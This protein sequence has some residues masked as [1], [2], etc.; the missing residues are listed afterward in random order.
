[1]IRARRPVTVDDVRQHGAESPV[2]RVEPPVRPRRQPREP[3]QVRDD[4]L[5][6]KLRQQDAQQSFDLA[7]R[8]VAYVARQE[9][10]G[11]YREGDRPH[12]AV[13]G[14]R[15]A[16]RPRVDARH[17]DIPHRAHIAGDLRAMECWLH[18]PPLPAVVFAARQHQPVAYQAPG[19]AEIDAFLEL[20]GLADQ[21]MPN[22]VWA[23][24]HVNGKPQE[25][26]ADHIA[27]FSRSLEQPERVTAELQR[28]PEHSPS[29]RHLRY[30]ARDFPGSCGHLPRSFPKTC[31]QD[32]LPGQRTRSQDQLPERCSWSACWSS[33]QA[34][35][36]DDR[37]EAPYGRSEKSSFHPERK[38]G[39]CLSA[40]DRPRG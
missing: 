15:P 39:V 20:P 23:V 26:D 2:S 6:Q 22:G 3:R 4:A 37:E 5:G 14:E 27:V 7:D 24:Q 33:A 30:F 18:K 34:G 32:V 17:R 35:L 21:R 13:E 40:R 29:P 12:F 19:P 25:P 1:M 11:Q 10:A 36:R 16:V 31:I 9:R 28:V 38:G 8:L